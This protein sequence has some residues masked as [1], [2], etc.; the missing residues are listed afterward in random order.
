MGQ[1]NSGFSLLELLV[2]L[3]VMAVLSTMLVVGLGIIPR[4]D[5]RSCANDLKS[6]IGQTRIMTMGK[7]KTI[8]EIT[9]SAAD[10]KYYTVEKTDDGS[11]TL[12]ESQPEMV[13]KKSLTVSYH[14]ENG[15]ID[16]LT[17]LGNYVKLEQG[18]ALDISFDRGSGKE[19]SGGSPGAST[20]CD[21]ILIEG[22]GAKYFVRI[23]TATG[24]ITME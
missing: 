7:K 14:L 17:D 5:A 13:G 15:G 3:A 12:V 22:G 1:D 10:G 16:P 8:L 9:H 19:L 6:A 11:G 18:D 23:Y 21:A 2:A 20:L 24:K 4:T